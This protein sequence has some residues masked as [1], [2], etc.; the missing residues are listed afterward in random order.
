MHSGLDEQTRIHPNHS[1]ESSSSESSDGEPG[2]L[3]KLKNMFLG[4]DESRDEHNTS[5]MTVG[6]STVADRMGSALATR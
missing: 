6:S 1:I 3:S 2:A 4:R 5:Q